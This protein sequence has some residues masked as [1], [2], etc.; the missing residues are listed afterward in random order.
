M[1][2]GRYGIDYMI[3]P[4]SL[5]AGKLDEVPENAYGAYVYDNFYSGDSSKPDFQAYYLF[6]GQKVNI[7]DALKELEGIKGDLDSF[8]MINKKRFTELKANGYKE[9]VI[10]AMPLNKPYRY[11]TLSCFQ[12]KPIGP[13]DIVVASNLELAVLVSKMN[14][15]NFEYNTSAQTTDKAPGHRL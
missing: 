4:A 13:R 12:I 9:A 3:T 8:E 5:N 1:Q 6:V 11:D 7:E 15:E 10:L 2:K 14:N